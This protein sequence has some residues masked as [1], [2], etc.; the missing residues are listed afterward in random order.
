MRERVDESYRFALESAQAALR[1]NTG[2]DAESKR[3]LIEAVW[4]IAAADGYLQEAFGSVWRD[5]KQRHKPA[6][7]LSGIYWARNRAIHDPLSIE[8]VLRVMKLPFHA[9]ELA[10]ARAP[11]AEEE[12]WWGE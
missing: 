10:E 12:A 5:H 4:W 9:P 1:R 6:D 3:S 2:L 7:L 8:K 11:P